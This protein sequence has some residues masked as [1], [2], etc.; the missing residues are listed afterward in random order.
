MYIVVEIKVYTLPYD[1]IYTIEFDHSHNIN[2]W[3]SS[4]QEGMSR[5]MYN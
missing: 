5:R 4:T 3:I 2:V 1:Y